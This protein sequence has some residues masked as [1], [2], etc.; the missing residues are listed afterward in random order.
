MCPESS[1]N[2]FKKTLD[3]LLAGF[4]YQGIVAY[5]VY[6]L[7]KHDTPYFFTYTDSLDIYTQENRINEFFTKN[8]LDLLGNHIDEMDK[9]T[10]CFSSHLL[11]ESL[12]TLSA[13]Y[14][15]ISIPQNNLHIKNSYLR[16][17]ANIADLI[18]ESIIIDEKEKIVLWAE[19]TKYDEKSFTLV[20]PDQNLYNG[21]LGLLYF[22][23]L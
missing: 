23:I 15:I 22:F 9:S 19:A 14:E 10:I 13:D 17:A 12:N 3:F 2:F 8:M 16:K 5:E 21:T 6:S 11:E 1:K 20:Y 18:V 4:I 7:V